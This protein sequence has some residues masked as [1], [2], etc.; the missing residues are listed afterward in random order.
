[1]DDFHNFH[2]EVEAR[3]Q[4]LNTPPLAVAF[5]IRLGLRVL[6][7]L[8]FGVEEGKEFLW[9]WKKSDR[10]KH[11]LAVLRAY[12]AACW[13]VVD[14]AAS[15]IAKAAATDLRVADEEARLAVITSAR[16]VVYAA[17]FVADTAAA[18]T[19]ATRATAFAMKATTMAAELVNLLRKEL[20]ALTESLQ[21]VHYLQISLW[22][23]PPP[24]VVQL[25]SVFMAQLRKAEDE[26][27]DYWADWLEARWLGK[28]LETEHLKQSVWLD[29]TITSKGPASINAYLK[30]LKSRK[31]NMPLNRVRAIFIGSGEAGKTSLIRVL[32]GEA[33]VE[34][35]EPM[36]PGVEIYRWRLPN[37]S[38]WADLWDFGG[39]VMAHAT[40]Q[41]FLRERCLYV[42]VLQA[43]PQL[44][45]N[46]EAKYWLEH[47]RAFGK[48]AP[49]LVVG[50]KADLL[51]LS[52]DQNELREKYPNIVNF[53]DISCTEAR[54][55]YLS[56]FTRFC[57]DFIKQLK[58]LDMHNLLLPSEHL[59]LLRQLEQHSTQETF[60]SQAQFAK[61][62][63][64]WCIPEKGDLDREWLLDLLDK[65]GVVIHFPNLPY[66]KDFVLN[67]RWLTYG[68]YTLLYSKQLEIQSGRLRE[69]EVPNILQAQRV[70]DNLGNMLRYPTD[71]CRFIVEAMVQFQMCYRLPTN[72]NFLI[73]P[74]KLSPSRPALDFDKSETLAFDF[75]CEGFLPRHLM[76]T[77]IVQHHADIDGV[78]WQNGVQLCSHSFAAKALMEA[79]EHNRRLSLWV[80]GEQADWYFA[81]LY[82]TIKRMFGKMPKL[83]VQEWIR[84]P[85]AE[86]DPVDPI[87]RASFQQLLAI[88]HSGEDKYFGA[89]GSL[90][91]VGKLL[92]IMPEGK[93]PPLSN[94]SQLQL[95]EQPMQP[96]KTVYQPQLWEKLMVSLTGLGFCVLIG[97]L[98]V[99][100][101][102]FADPNLVVLARILLSV[103]VGTFSAAIPGFLN[104][105][106]SAKGLTI[107]ATG[108][109]A[110]GVLTFIMTPTVLSG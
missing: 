68:V 72:E 103:M 107:R 16:A 79:D 35:K 9:F 102:P 34:G 81:A 54:G 78:V 15:K 41:F 38:I 53:Y 27:F 13:V 61:M 30:S 31:S 73:I 90:Y 88:K 76:A 96:D 108:A 14:P 44:N 39:Q 40:H 10:S 93:L 60:L 3:L 110:M 32:Q 43:R 6:P 25:H 100:N 56:H 94:L 74:A 82:D 70:T 11:L 51:R 66:V 101:E 49:V 62:C 77:F 8:A 69:Q 20:A 33:V 59:S 63:K 29:E 55:D 91:S 86:T 18:I 65:L 22:K 12:S 28:A 95:P 45:P 36:T 83:L 4:E 104:V 42:L 67:P 21:P 106:F 80:K 23:N 99:R 46:E 58:Q 7:T 87:R 57:E 17:A 89:D 26:G 71:K 84:L 92:R 48:D 64:V 97:F 37:S 19:A 5:A 75:D 47:V 1:V 85:G 98:L 105:G 2:N 24:Q 50:N 109:L 52:L